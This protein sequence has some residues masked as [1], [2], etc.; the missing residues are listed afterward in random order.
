M[1]GDYT[2]V[3]FDAVNAFS[4]V[5]KQQGR[6]SLD[7]DFN[8]FEEILD[9]SSRARMYDTVGQAVVPL[10]T[11]H[12]FEIL[13]NAAGTLTIGVGR[14]YVDGILAECFGDMSDP[15]ATLRDD[16]LGGVV[17]PQPVAFDKQP[18][19][20]QPNFPALS[21]TAG[22]TNLVYLDVWQREVTVLEDPGLREPALNGPDTAT[23]VQT[24]W[25][26]KVMQAAA[27]A[28]SCAAP[29]AAWTTLVA[30]STARLTAQA[31][32]LIPPAA[33]P[34]IINPA[35]GYTGIENRLYRVEVHQAGTLGGGSPAQFKWSR[36]N[37]SLAANVLSV[38]NISATQSLITVSSTGRDAW[39]R[40]QHGDH[41]ELLD[42]YVEFA[43]RESNVGG[44]MASVLSVNDATGEITV[45]ADLSTFTIVPGRHPRIRRWDSVTGETLVRP[46]NPG[47]ALPLEE[48]IS[49]TFDGAATDTL[50]AGDYWVFAARTADGSIDQLVNA[51]PRGILHHFA[52]LAL[53]TSGNPPVPQTSCRTFWPPAVHGEGCCSAVVHP[54]EDIQQAIDSLTA[55]GGGCVCLK[56]G[57]HDIQGPLIIRQDNLTIHGEVP[58]VTVR[59]QQGGPE[60]LNVQPT[61]SSAGNISILGIQFVAEKGS[62]LDPMITVR[63]VN[64]GRIADCELNN[65]A[66]IHSG[67]QTLGIR[68]EEC[69]DY[70][71]ESNT[72]MGFASGVEGD[73]SPGSRILDNTITGLSGSVAGQSVSVGLLGINFVDD[74]NPV[75]GT[76]VERNVL[77]DFRRGIQLGQVQVNGTAITTVGTLDITAVQ[78]G[79]RIAEN[80]VVRQGTDPRVENTLAF[81]I[82]A[83]VSRCEIV[84]N[85]MSIVA[86]TDCGIIA[87]GG[88]A[89]IAR[90]QV[91]S[92][93]K[94][95]SAAAIKDAQVPLPLGI[96]AYVQEGDVLRCTVQS[97]LC[98]G[99]QQAI[100]VA[101]PGAT[102]IGH[103]EVFDNYV[104]G[105]P[106]L[107][108]AV[109]S[110]FV[111]G[112]QG[113]NTNAISQL[114]P[115]FEN[116][117]SIV[118]KGVKSARVATNNVEGALLGIYAL[119]SN[120][121]SVVA[122]RLME[123]IVAAAL[124]QTL[125]SDATDN[126]V[127]GAL[128][129]GL[130]LLKT[131]RST[132]ARNTL[133]VAQ[134]GIVSTLGVLP[135][136]EGNSVSGGSIGLESLQDTDADIRGNTVVDTNTDGITSS[137]GVHELTLAQNR[138]QRC[139]Y[140][141][142]AGALAQATGI[143]ALAFSGDVFV[144]ACD[145]ID[146]GESSLA[147]D[148]PFIGIR[149]GVNVETIG[150]ARVRGCVVSSQPLAPGQAPNGSSRAIRILIRTNAAMLKPDSFADATD[151]VAI[152][153]TGTL[154]EISGPQEVMFA[155]N[156]C[157]NIAADSP[158]Q[159]AAVQLTGGLVTV[160][161]N[162]VRSPAEPP[163][164]KVVASGACSAV[165]NIT[166]NGADI[167]TASLIP[168]PYGTFNVPAH[169]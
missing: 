78:P 13:V 88:N 141:S 110:A 114:M 118:V 39:M 33:G 132:V 165:G 162:R 79:C 49:I 48:G 130:L 96:V 160:T 116:Y 7:S 81:A 44:P 113:S 63:S 20:Y 90:N 154:V 61:S 34:C 27:D 65:V 147:N 99:L 163:S 5:H 6:V 108:N 94:F 123:C 120:G 144:S 11:Q 139:G 4:G 69:Q 168:T 98:T 43:M 86:M 54:G 51:P 124:A 142:Q 66:G 85:A 2:R 73:A 134:F 109:V 136:L 121:V 107:V 138:A 74:K 112:V 52:R 169:A 71:I 53:V 153:A 42:D 117:A 91:H 161:G 133:T 64:G 30:P 149:L 59:R 22:T 156:R 125:L 167:A 3:T 101:G 58:W 166:T 148:P 93:V 21:A 36:D 16:T 8:E 12:A 60:M 76:R 137:L 135:R 1:G 24:A 158:F 82:A 9:R 35:G 41:I 150:N 83:H 145:V 127:E 28:N 56:M 102:S 19:F 80:V 87:A 122:N 50:H 57:T 46:T 75:V 103:T 45:D 157:M 128:A 115:L 18:F 155:S 126:L 47:A 152:Q 32:P 159:V 100:L 106:D 89:L 164:L 31:T 40:F 55:L 70:V 97:N 68:L 38:T 140:R 37:A 26:V 129:A 119:E 29:P 67:A 23:R 14:A 10:T 111:H 72:L 131:T 62:G 146:V 17:G 84:E 15:T 104:I 77:T 25:Q 143:S 92:S 151:N 95:D 105:S